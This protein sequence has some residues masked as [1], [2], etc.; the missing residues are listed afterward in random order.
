MAEKKPFPILIISDAPSAT[1]GL[2]RITRELAT[3]LHENLG[4]VCRVATLGYGGP[5]SCNY[6]FQQYAI[7]GMSD[8]VIPTLPQVWDDFAGQEKGAIFTIW[9]ASRL[10][11]FSQPARCGLLTANPL[12]RQW[13]VQ[14]PF[15]RWG[16][17]PIDAKGPNGKLSFPLQQTYLGFDRI[18]AYGN[19][20]KDI[21]QRSIGDGEAS[22]R[23]LDSLPHGI[24]T[25]IFYESD[26]KLCRFL[27]LK[28]TGAEAF[29]AA[30][31][32]IANDE[33]LVG[34]VATNQ[35]RKD[36]ALGIEAVSLLAKQRKVRLWIHT[37][38]LE[39]HWSIPALL[40]DYG[41]LD[42]TMVSLGFLPDE[43]MAEAYSAC[44][45]TLGIGAEGYGYPLAESQACGTPVVTGAYA[46]GAE[47]VPREMQVEPIAYRAEG[48]YSSV[49]PVFNASDW[50]A[51][52][53][54]MIGR[55][56][57]LDPQYAWQNLWPRWETWFCKGIA[58]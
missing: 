30:P 40:I 13:L 12:L 43:K 37:D 44:D 47:I 38:Q 45:A 53:E 11:W 55:R 54:K 6:G 27:F 57:S 39:R 33:I 49:R 58:G 28:I 50:A 46:G 1:S 21:L 48:L 23:D 24:D 35:D 2:A 36:W 52:A 19:W 3:R 41:L 56:V 5:G 26:R 29:T 42:K 51:K 17:F 4:D 9:D 10:T 31:A 15:Q 34:I 8:W 20:A 7:E 14:A 18:L 32:A 16:Y 22:K 25:D